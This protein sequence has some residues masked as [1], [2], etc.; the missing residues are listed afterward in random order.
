[1]TVSILVVT[2]WVV[3]ITY[4]DVCMFLDL[5]HNL[6]LKLCDGCMMIIHG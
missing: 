4:D 5:A 6:P 1:M 2:T 3:D